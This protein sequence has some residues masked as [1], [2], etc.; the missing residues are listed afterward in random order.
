MKSLKGY[1][2]EVV[3]WQGSTSRMIFDVGTRITDLKIPISSSIF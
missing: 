1:L 3:Q 2:E